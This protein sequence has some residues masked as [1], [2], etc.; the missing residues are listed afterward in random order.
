MRWR[1]FRPPASIECQEL[2]EHITD[3]L[4]GSLQPELKA[5]I[6]HHLAGCK[7]CT[8][9]L[10]QMRQTVAAARGAE[11]RKLD[12]SVKSELLQAFRAERDKD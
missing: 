7:D 5:R 8:E 9:F 11:V 12:V 3:Y 10:R 2:V 1:R 4:E 6:D